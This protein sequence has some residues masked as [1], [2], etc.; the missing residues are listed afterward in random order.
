MC[1]Q[2]ASRLVRRVSRLQGRCQRATY[3]R[4]Y[5]C[6]EVKGASRQRITK[7]AS[8]ESNCPSKERLRRLAKEASRYERLR[9]C[10][11]MHAQR[12]LIEGKGD[13]FPM[14]RV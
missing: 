13:V 14:W 4:E 11:C 3:F 9:F 1:E 8:G 7:E 2:N 6:N 10:R 12:F 5:V